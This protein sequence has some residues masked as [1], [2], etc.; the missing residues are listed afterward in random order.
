MKVKTPDNMCMMC[1]TVIP[2]GRKACPHCEA[3]VS[4]TTDKIMMKVNDE[5]EQAFR[6]GYT[7]GFNE[8]MKMACDLKQ[9]NTQLRKDIAILRAAIERRDNE[10]N[11][12]GWYE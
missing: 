8:G 4:E 7:A 11:Q 1:G 3:A 6:Q 12:D 9:Q 5:L 10:S 2:E